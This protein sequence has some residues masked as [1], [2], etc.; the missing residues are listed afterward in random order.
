M[1]DTNGIVMQ[2]HAGQ[3]I[4]AIFIVLSRTGMC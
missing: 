2:G 1:I 3:Q 4:D